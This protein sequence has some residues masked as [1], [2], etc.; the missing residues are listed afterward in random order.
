MKENAA[1]QD[2][3][4]QKDSSHT[5]FTFLGGNLALDLVN[6]EHMA[7]GKR[8][9]TLLTPADVTRW[10]EMAHQTYPQTSQSQGWREQQILALRTVRQELR[11]LFETLIANHPIHENQLQTLNS[12]LR[13][14]SYALEVLPEGNLLTRYRMRNLQEGEALLAIAHAAMNLLTE[15]DLSRLHVCQ[16]ERCMLLFYDTTRSATRHW[17]SVACSNRARSLQNYRQAKKSEHSLQ[18]Q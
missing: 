4:Y 17:C 12:I 5:Q 16:N 3:I 10:W 9:D 18:N 1:Y 13:Q 14:G 15:Q 6:T 7:R 2:T 11:N 8:V